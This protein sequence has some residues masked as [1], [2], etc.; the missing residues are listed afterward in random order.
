MSAP[1]EN[2]LAR[3]ERVKPRPNG[4]GYMA[5]CPTAAHPRGDRNASL[6]VDEGNNGG[7]IFYCFSHQC[8]A[9]AI[10][11]ALG[12]ELTDLFPPRLDAHSPKPHIPS[13]P[14]RELFAGIEPSLVAAGMA[15]NRLA[16]GQPIPPDE[17]AYFQGQADILWDAIQRARGSRGR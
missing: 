16:L 12:L 4:K 14:W 5:A 11:A 15:F 7:V 1:L 17:A 3:L 10:A 8:S 6:A 13:V 9:E 2:V